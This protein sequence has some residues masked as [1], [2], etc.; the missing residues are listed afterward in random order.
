MEKNIDKFLANSERWG[1]MYRSTINVTISPV[2]WED[3]MNHLHIHVGLFADTMPS[4][5]KKTSVIALFYDGD[6]YQSSYDC[7]IW[8][9]REL[10]P[11]GIYL[12][13]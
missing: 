2:K 4:A 12:S 6:M 5:L 9:W 10:T 8:L 1:E 3:A 13:R 7:F 11:S